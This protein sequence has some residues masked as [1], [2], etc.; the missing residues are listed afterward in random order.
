M[1]IPGHSIH[2][3]AREIVCIIVVVLINTMSILN[4]FLFRIFTV[5]F[6]NN[7][8]LFVAGG[9]RREQ[10][11]NIWHYEQMLQPRAN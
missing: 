9:K 2:M 4:L 3:E 5:I 1:T 11:L 7:E 6:F 8:S 10:S